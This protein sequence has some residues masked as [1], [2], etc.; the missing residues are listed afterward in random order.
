MDVGVWCMVVV[1]VGVSEVDGW[2]GFSVEGWVEGWGIRG[3][4]VI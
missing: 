3:F 4:N 2:V 1:F